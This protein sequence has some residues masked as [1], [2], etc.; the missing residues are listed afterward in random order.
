M[1][2]PCRPLGRYENEPTDGSA[3]P[4]IVISRTIRGFALPSV[5]YF[6]ACC[7]PDCMNAGET[8]RLLSLDE[9]TPHE[10][11]TP[12]LTGRGWKV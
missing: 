2:L 1:Q 8:A 4:R 9:K 6:S 12:I 5:G 11:A 3:N 10:V 7:I